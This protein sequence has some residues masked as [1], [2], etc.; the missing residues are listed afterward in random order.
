M[1]LGSI[2]DADFRPRQVPARYPEDNISP[3]SSNNLNF[4]LNPTASDGDSISIP[5][6]ASPIVSPIPPTPFPLGRDIHVVSEHEVAFLLRH[7]GETTGQWMDLFDLG[8]YFGHLA[9]VQAISNPL[10]KY[11][12]CAYAAKQ[13]WRVQGR[14]AVVGDIVGRQADMEYVHRYARAWNV[15]FN[16]FFI[17]HSIAELC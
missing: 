13:L 15:A 16:N 17:L 1:W 5:S 6:L 2:R 8:C 12:A 11:S 3:L 9:P 7:F 4:I 10:L 14:K